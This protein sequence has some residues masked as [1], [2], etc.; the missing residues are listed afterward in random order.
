MSE[1]IWH[2]LK[3]ESSFK[4]KN[5]EIKKW[6]LNKT[7]L[8][9]QSIQSWFDIKDN[10]F[11]TYADYFVNFLKSNSLK[12]IANNKN[13]KNK[14]AFEDFIQTHLQ[15]PEYVGKYVVFVDG[16]F[17]KHGIDKI[18][19]VKEMYD[20]F[21]NIEMYIAKISSPKTTIVIDTPEFV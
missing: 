15:N 21:G 4:Q 2:E 11:C 5:P 8:Y 13:S 6:N 19:L 18:A 20:K 3:E 9:P 17:Q 7:E 16:H 14:R 1:N 12:D 10:F